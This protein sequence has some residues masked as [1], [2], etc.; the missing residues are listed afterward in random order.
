MQ[1]E[2]WGKIS[3]M[4]IADRNVAPGTEPNSK[5]RHCLR[6]QSFPAFL[7]RGLN[8]THYGHPPQPG[9][10]RTLLV[11]GRV[12]N[13]P[14][15][16][17]NC[18]AGWFLGGG[19]DALR[20]VQLCAGTTLLYLGGMFLNDAFDAL[21]DQQ[22]RRERPIPSG[23]VGQEDVW[24]WGI[25]LLVLGFLALL[26]FGKTTLI[27]T[28][29]LIGAIVLYDAIHKLIALSP[30][31]IAVCR[32]LL[33][34]IAASAG[35]E[36]ITGLVIWSALVLAAYIVGLSYL[37]RKESLPGTLRY[38]PCLFLAAPVVLALV[39]NVGEYQTRGV[40]LSVAL[41]LWTL[42]SLYFAFW[43]GQRHIGRSVSGLLAGIVLVDLLA[44]AGG[45][46]TITMVTI[47][48][49]VT[50]LLFQRYIPAT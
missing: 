33:Y 49:F 19:G 40:L 6:R 42:R 10:F 24:R 23:L 36:G 34:L 20:L 14:T 26:F 37:A 22:Q 16:W 17:S 2:F 28:L 38:W 21:F 18:L 45:T 8:S 25:G 15:V 47:S 11:L 13:L 7:L 12:S 3:I 4:M 31:L 5:R 44:V 30:V 35:L 29:F 46:P 9:F 41:L 1:R 27:L 43:A 50:A 48:L 39:V 32:F